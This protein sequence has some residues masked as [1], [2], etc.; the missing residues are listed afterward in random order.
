MSTMEKLIPAD[1]IIF[2]NSCKHFLY[3]TN[4]N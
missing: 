2:L 4:Q 1:Y 3:N